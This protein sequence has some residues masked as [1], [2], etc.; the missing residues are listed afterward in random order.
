MKR[1]IVFIIAAVFALSSLTAKAETNGSTIM[2]EDTLQ[3]TQLSE[4]EINGMVARIHEIWQMD[5]SNLTVEEKAG[6]R[7]EVSNINDAFKFENIVIYISV[8]TLIII[9]ILLLILL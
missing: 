7:R 8:T 5:K 2:Y 9:L 6:L 4:E 1:T 3:K